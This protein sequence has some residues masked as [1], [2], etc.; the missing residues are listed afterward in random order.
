MKKSVIEKI[1]AREILDCRGNPTI[2]VDVITEDGIQGRADAPA[3]RSRGKY[4]AFEIRDGDK[5]YKVEWLCPLECGPASKDRG[6]RRPVHPPAPGP[7]EG[8]TGPDGRSG[9]GRGS[10]R[11]YVI[12]PAIVLS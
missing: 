2:Q 12:Y 11:A 7:N 10:A 9:P 5:R 1:K 6:H 3:G 8:T 4:E